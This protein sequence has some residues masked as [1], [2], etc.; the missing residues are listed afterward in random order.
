MYVRFISCVDGTLKGEI[1]KIKPL[2]EC[3][4]RS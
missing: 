3:W 2:D 4:D 1:I